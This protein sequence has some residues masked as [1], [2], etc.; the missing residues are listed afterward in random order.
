MQLL[1]TVFH[2]VVG[3]LGSTPGDELGRA[4][5]EGAL[6]PKA[7]NAFHQGGIADTVP[8][9]PHPVLMEEPGGNVD[10]ECPR[11]GLSDL[12]DTYAQPGA[13]V[14]DVGGSGS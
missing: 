4:R 1:E 14:Q 12:S 11:Q 5:L 8:N 9:V 2:K 6:S 7:E 13:D 10:T 3:G